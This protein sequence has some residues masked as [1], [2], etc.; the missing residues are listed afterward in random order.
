MVY[1]SLQMVGM[2]KVVLE[3]FFPSRWRPITCCTASMRGLELFLV[4]YF[5]PEMKLV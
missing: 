2:V 3:T 4:T 1:G 5:A